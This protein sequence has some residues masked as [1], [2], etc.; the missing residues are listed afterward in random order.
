MRCIVLAA[1]CELLGGAAL[2]EEDSYPETI[3]L[4]KDAGQS[5]KFFGNS[6]GYAL[7]PTIGKGGLGIGGAYGKGR[8]YRG[9]QHVGDTSVTQVSFGLQAGGQSY[10]EIIFFKDKRAFDDFT[11]GNF[12][13]GTK[14]RIR[15]VLSP[16]PPP[17]SSRST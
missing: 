16:G 6:Y 1:A 4:L 5:A 17:A 11:S 9:G 10:S 15:A 8:V 7:F 13:F 12:E 3:R 2:A 14:R